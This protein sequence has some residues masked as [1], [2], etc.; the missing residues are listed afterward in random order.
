M[1]GQ[2]VVDAPGEAHAVRSSCD[3]ACFRVLRY[4][5]THRDGRTAAQFRPTPADLSHKGDLRPA[6]K[7][8]HPS[9]LRRSRAPAR[10]RPAALQ[11]GI[12]R[13]SSRRSRVV[14]KVAA[15]QHGL[16]D[17]R[18]PES[19]VWA[20]SFPR[21]RA[22][23]TSGVIVGQNRVRLW[24]K[25]ASSCGSRGPAHSDAA[26]QLLLDGAPALLVGDLTH[27]DRPPL[28][29]YSRSISRIAPRS[30]SAR[31]NDDRD[32]SRVL[33][34]ASPSRSSRGPCSRISSRVARR[35]RFRS[36]QIRAQVIG[37]EPPASAAT[38]LWRGNSR[39]APAAA[40]RVH[41][42]AVDHEAS[43]RS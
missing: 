23:V 13:S 39:S 25:S 27:T 40:R 35:R 30:G 21:F 22:V 8:G 1:T 28:G 10:R 41:D 37:I 14:E 31:R 33:R 11:R 18:A 17:L 29:S 19:W 2:S 36:V 43:P 24:P 16:D 9:S 4:G 12:L 38:W 42:L 3:A 20:R 7:P 34:G 26:D 32:K 15:S 5:S 6:A